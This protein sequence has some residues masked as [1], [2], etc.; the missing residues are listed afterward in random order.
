[1]LKVSNIDWDIDMDEVMEKL[2]ELNEAETL[3]VLGYDKT[4]SER[5]KKASDAV[6][7]DMAEST[8][9]HCPGLLYDF[10]ELPESL[11][12]SDEYDKDQDVVDYLSDTYGYC[13]KSLSVETVITKLTPDQRERLIDYLDYENGGTFN[14]GVMKKLFGDEP[15][16]EFHKTIEE[17]LSKNETKTSDTE[18]EEEVEPKFLEWD[19]QQIAKNYKLTGYIPKAEEMTQNWHADGPSAESTVKISDFTENG[20]A[21]I[22]RLRLPF[23]TKK[24]LEFITFSWSYEYGVSFT[25]RD[26]DG[27]EEG[28]FLSGEEEI[29]LM[30][31]NRLKL[32]EIEHNYSSIEELR[33]DKE[34]Q[35]MSRY[36]YKK[37]LLE[38]KPVFA[39]TTNQQYE[40]ILWDGINST[41]CKF[42]EHFGLIEE[43]I[44]DVDDLTSEIRDFILDK[45]ERRG[46]KLVDVFTQY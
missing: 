31:D 23:G 5:W 4:L 29:V 11:E 3:K 14:E 18:D 2:D 16:P 28:G 45:Y 22:E 30:K 20:Q 25:T 43:I 44:L 1:M 42:E 26:I 27:T 39:C 12:L 34:L 32:P 19:Y 36:A 21:F 15:L 10:L 37:V 24:P 33:A 9:R 13:I 6:R 40:D 38:G 35:N 46:V 17:N 41:L 7:M 8:F